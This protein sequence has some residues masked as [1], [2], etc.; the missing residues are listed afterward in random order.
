MAPESLLRILVGLALLTL[1]RKLFWLFVAAAGF[2]AGMEI[3][4]AVVGARESWLVLAI[5]IG[6]GL[7]GAL[8]AIAMQK[9]AIAIAGFL[10]GGYVAA[11][12]VR[13]VVAAPASWGWIPYIIGGVLGAILVLVVFDWALILLSSVSGALL[14]ADSLK[15]ERGVAGLVLVALAVAGIVIQARLLARSQ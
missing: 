10:A 9:I 7:V 1:G 3:G 13:N 11:V 2:L 14:V 15:L 12:L 4:P 6:A 5:A 8:L